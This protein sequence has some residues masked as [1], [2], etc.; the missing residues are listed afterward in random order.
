ML[1]RSLLSNPI[2]SWFG[3]W[4]GVFGAEKMELLGSDGKA[5][6]D[7]PGTCADMFEAYLG[8]LIL[9]RGLEVATKWIGELYSD[10]VL[11]TLAED[12]EDERV[13]EHAKI[14]AP[15]P[16]RNA[17]SGPVLKRLREADSS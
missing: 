11:S 8:A 15:V 6:A 14:T 13:T 16:A 17:S 4:Y 1:F 7:S 5:K 2:I 12:L 3:W 10:E 9:D